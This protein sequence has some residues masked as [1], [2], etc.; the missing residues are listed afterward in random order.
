MNQVGEKWGHN[1]GTAQRGHTGRHL[2]GNATV[3]VFA[4]TEDVS[5]SPVLKEKLTFVKAATA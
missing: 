4:V 5:L 2:H 1:G 3:T